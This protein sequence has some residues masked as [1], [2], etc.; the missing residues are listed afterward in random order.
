MDRISWGNS[1]EVADFDQA[2]FAKF[3]DLPDEEIKNACMKDGRLF[4]IIRAEHFDRGFLE[5][6]YQTAHA[7][8]K[9]AKVDPQWL[10]N[11]LP[12]KSILNYF[13]QPSSRTFLSFSMAEAHLGMQREEVRDIKTS[14]AVKGESEKDALRTVSS[15]F[16]ALVV[17]HPGDVYDL[18]GVWVMKNSDREIT[19]INAGSGQGEHPTQG[20]LDYYTKRESFQRALDGMVGVYVGDCLRGRTVHSDAKIMALHK[21]VTLYFVAPP[22]LQIDPDTEKYL[23][24]NGVR[25]HKV[26]QG[27]EYVFPSRSMTG[28]V[29]FL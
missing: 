25:V 22:H 11:L 26:H 21:D 7:T 19:V 16:D 6:I 8:R 17:R 4:H 13:N 23:Q 3:R 24:A 14:S 15:Y 28:G 10:A 29:K 20:L 5:T 2:Q 12:Y 27:L 18:F 1:K 9:M